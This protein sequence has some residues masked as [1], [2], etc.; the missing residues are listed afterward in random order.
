V[1]SIVGLG[2]F[3][4]GDADGVGEAVRLQHPLGITMGDGVLYVADTYNHKIKQVS[5]ATRAVLTLFGTGRSRHD[6]GPHNAA[7]FSEP[8]GLSLAGTKLYIADTNNHA[9]RVAEL[10]AKTVST[11]EIRGV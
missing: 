3:E 8:S 1:G 10:E 11:L 4:F 5:P 2:L 6:D 9:I 7:T